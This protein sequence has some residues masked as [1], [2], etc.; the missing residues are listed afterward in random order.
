MT[1]TKPGRGGARP[2]AGR[3][4]RAQQ[5]LPISAGESPLVF[6][7]QVM[8][9]QAAEL[10]LRIEA[11]RAALPYMHQKGGVLGKKDAT[12]EAARRLS[13]GR[14]SPGIAPGLSLVRK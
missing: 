8:N 4:K 5:I 14:F 12:K 3:P 13:G 11:A 1:T 9:N 7:L 6:L 10:K 2:G